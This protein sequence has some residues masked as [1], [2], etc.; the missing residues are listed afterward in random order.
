MPARLLREGI[1]DSESV[2]SLKW[3]EEVFYRRLMS[4]VDDFG[5]FDGRPAVLKSRLYPLQTDKVREADITRWIAACVKAGLIALY[6]VAGKQYIL[7]G[8]LGVP[9]ATTSKWPAPPTGLE[10]WDTSGGDDGT[11]HLHTDENKPAQVNA[12]ENGCG[13]TPAF[14]PYSDSGSDSDT[15]TGSVRSSEVDK[16]PSLP[17]VLTFPTVGEGG[18]TW[19]LTAAQLDRWR[20]LYPGI[21]VLAECRKA[22]GWCEA[23]PKKRKTVGGMAKFLVNWLNGTNDKGSGGGAKTQKTTGES[24]EE[25]A[26]RIRAEMN[27]T[28]GTGGLP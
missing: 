22:L 19:P 17:P 14:A 24:Q 10:T 27:A 20:S 28:N 23:N 12:D 1:L 11:P 6:S 13:Q 3:E 15:G 25:R 9:R 4:V 16:P 26:K 21:D 18:D 2:C 7:F 8:K 5:R